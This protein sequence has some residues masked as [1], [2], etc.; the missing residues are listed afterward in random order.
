VQ[1]SGAKPLLDLSNFENEVQ[2]VVVKVQYT[3][4]IIYNFLLDPHLEVNLLN[5]KQQINLRRTKK[6]WV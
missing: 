3:E 1:P 6:G 4:S 5:L 2:E